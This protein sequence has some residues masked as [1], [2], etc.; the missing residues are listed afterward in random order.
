VRPVAVMEL[1]ELAQSVE[2]VP[3]VPDLVPLARVDA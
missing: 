1:L 3:M 2:Q